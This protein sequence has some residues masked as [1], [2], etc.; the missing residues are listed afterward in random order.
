MKTRDN[1]IPGKEYWDA[2]W[3][4]TIA[5]KY[6]IDNDGNVTIQTIKRYGKDSEPRVLGPTE[7]DGFLTEIEKQNNWSESHGY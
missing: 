1:M 6:C 7:Y 2:N 3:N 5:N 4:D